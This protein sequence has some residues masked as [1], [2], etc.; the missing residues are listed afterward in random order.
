MR[1][2]MIE[3]EFPPKFL[4]Q[5]NVD[6]N[7]DMNTNTNTLEK[8]NTLNKYHYWHQVHLDIHGECIEAHRTDEGD[9]KGEN[10][11]LM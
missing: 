3:A 9:P 6:V 10:D 5:P 2:P 11:Y 7:M 4:H 8:I 1:M